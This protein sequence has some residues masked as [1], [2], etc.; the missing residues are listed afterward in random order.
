MA[1]LALR[2]PQ[3]HPT[4]IKHGFPNRFRSLAALAIPALVVACWGGEDNAGAGGRVTGQGGAPNG[5]G[6]DGGDGHRV[7]LTDEMNY[8]FSSSLSAATTHVRANADISFDWSG[9]TRDMQGRELDPVADVDMAQV[10][11]WRYDEESFLAGINEEEV[12]TGRIAAM[13]YCDTE[14]SRDSCQFFD[15]VA[16]GGIE[17]SPEALLEY[18]DPEIYPPSEHVWIVTLN[19][20]RAFGQGIR[21]LAFFQP[22]EGEAGTTVALTNDS[23]T[24]SYTVDLTQLE[25]IPIP[26]LAGDVTVSWVDVD[27]LTTNGMGAAWVPTRITDVAI[28]HYVGYTVA[29]LEEQFL[30]LEDLASEYY[31]ARLNTGQ[32]VRLSELVD[33]TGSAFPGIDDD[34]VW[35]FS[36]ICGSCHNPAPWFLSILSPRD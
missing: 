33:E 19:T 1:Q 20:G 36:L 35:L 7:I 9:V 18:V 31:G 25:P 17:M 12:E 2:S 3:R 16:P 4:V 23:T 22:S 21:L 26:Q 24:L 29:D 11:L 6:G 15:L 8:A 13:A 27:Q 28:A 14:K 32:E 5:G 34:G 10:M 30:L